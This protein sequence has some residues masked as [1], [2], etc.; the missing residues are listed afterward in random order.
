MAELNENPFDISSANTHQVLFDDS[1]V[2]FG[3]L[4]AL[5]KQAISMNQPND[6]SL[7]LS[8]GGHVHTVGEVLAEVVESVGPPED[9]PWDLPANRNE[10][11]EQELKKVIRQRVEKMKETNLIPSSD[12][13]LE[14]RDKIAMQEFHGEMLRHP[15]ELLSETIGLVMSN[16]YRKL[17]RPDEIANFDE[18][19]RACLFVDATNMRRIMNMME[20]NVEAAIYFFHHLGRERALAGCTTGGRHRDIARSRALQDYRSNSQNF[21]VNIYAGFSDDHRLRFH[22]LSG[23]T[24][25]ECVLL[26]R[27]LNQMRRDGGSKQVFTNECAKTWRNICRARLF[28][29]LDQSIRE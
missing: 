28:S 22:V 29:D 19:W 15:A 6:L 14:D 27:G 21:D 20:W 16:K 9:D 17:S 7:W 18:I 11:F 2:R 3:E 24:Y 1:L 8:W 25:R 10:A 12:F 23:I 4:E 13:S 5:R 26:S